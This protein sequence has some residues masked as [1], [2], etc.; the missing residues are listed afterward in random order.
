MAIYDFVKDPPWAKNRPMQPTGTGLINPIGQDNSSSV[1]RFRSLMNL[2]KGLDRLPY[3]DLMDQN[4]ATLSGL[5]DQLNT[6]TAPTQDLN[7]ARNLSRQEAYLRGIDGPLAATISS[8]AQG[9]VINDFQRHKIGLINQVLGLQ[10]QIAGGQQSMEIQQRWQ[11]YLQR[12]QKAQA[13][14][15]NQSA[16]FQAIG[17]LLGAGGGALIGGGAGIGPGMQI[18]GGVGT[19]A[20]Q[21]F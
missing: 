8:D 7:Q 18:G 12:L 19:L 15:A 4:L 6:A 17:S 20:G 1:D 11:A 21:L 2:N 14:A 5:L 16:L 10:S 3:Q 9:R 13:E